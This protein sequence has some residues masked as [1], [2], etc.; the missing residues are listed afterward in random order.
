MTE[1]VFA[2]T[3]ASPLNL[4]N[5]DK[6]IDV[7]GAVGG[8]DTLRI[9]NVVLTNYRWAIY[10]RR[11]AAVLIKNVTTVAG[12]RQVGEQ[13]AYGLA[14]GNSSNQDQRVDR[15][16]IDNFIVA[17]L[18]A[19]SNDYAS[20]NQD[21]MTLEKYNGLLLIKDSQLLGATDGVIDSKTPYKMIR[22]TIGP[23]YLQLRM[24]SGI[25]TELADVTIQ[26]NPNTTQANWQTWSQDLDNIHPYLGG[27]QFFDD[28]AAWSWA[29]AQAA[30]IAAVV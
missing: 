26:P 24:W 11:F 16:Y 9:E 18:E 22:T 21:C 14:L 27:E 1:V 15:T 6:I 28:P 12:A 5:V 30:A 7:I 13:F 17:S 20:F 3:V 2:G 25:R 10:A 23:S 19:P 29:D 4:T 8:K